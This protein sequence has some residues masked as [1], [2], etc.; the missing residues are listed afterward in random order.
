MLF[1]LLGPKDTTP[2]PK[3]FLYIPATAADAATVNPNGVETPEA[4][5]LSTFFIKGKPVFNNGPK[6]IPRN[7]PNCTN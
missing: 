2:N 6:S 5:G 3:F 7:P 4:N 1:T